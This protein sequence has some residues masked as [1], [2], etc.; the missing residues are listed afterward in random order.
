MRVIFKRTL[1]ETLKLSFLII[2]LA[3]GVLG[4]LFL[5][6]NSIYDSAWIPPFEYQLNSSL[7][8][9]HMVA[10]FLVCGA[11][12][13][14]IISSAGSGLIAGEVHEGTFR[15]LVSKPNSRMSILAGKILGMMIG[16]LILLVMSLSA[17]F[18]AEFI[19]AKPDSEIVNSLLS[20]APGYL[21]YGAIVML[22]FSSLATLLS[23][24][25]KKKVIAFLP[26]LLIMIIVLVLPMVLRI[27]L[28]LRG[29]ISTT[30]S[31]VDLNYHFGSLFK[32]CMGFCGGIN[33]TSEQLELPTILMNIYKQ[34]SIDRDLSRTYEW[35]S[36]TMD[37]KTVP[38]FILLC[39]YGA[40][41]VINYLASFTIIRRKDV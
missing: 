38:V 1:Q 14:I 5:G 11:A 21:L 12:L 13:M 40:L 30:L 31:Y 36:I 39:V 17:M 33:G 3:A 4:G 26:M 28:M 24:I 8:M 2:M 27:I 25:V 29:S 23:C 22:F 35:G 10:F 37:N 18:L 9:Q 19:Y 20:Y 16:T 32:W 34:A 15:I 6:A 7:I 41:T